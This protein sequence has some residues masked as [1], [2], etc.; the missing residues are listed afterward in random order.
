M[1][2]G[3]VLNQLLLIRHRIYIKCVSMY[4]YLTSIERRS[5]V[6]LVS[7][8]RPAQRHKGA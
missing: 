5:G 6:D 7:I 3:R 1:A 8:R 4:V 2:Q